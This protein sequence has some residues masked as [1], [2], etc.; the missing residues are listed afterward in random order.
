MPTEL[1]VANKSLLGQINYTWGALATNRRKLVSPRMSAA[2]VVPILR[3]AKDVVEMLLVD[4]AESIQNFVL[5][6]LNDAL[7]K[8]LQVRRSSWRLLD[9]AAR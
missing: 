9:L 1:S 3:H 6:R 7:D 5:E 2:M 4:N 8:R